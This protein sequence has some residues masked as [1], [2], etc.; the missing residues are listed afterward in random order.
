MDEAVFK[1]G[2]ELEEGVGNNGIINNK[3]NKEIS[4]SIDYHAVRKCFRAS[5]IFKI[6]S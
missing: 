4:N 2:S 6:V 5:E 1:I 3:T